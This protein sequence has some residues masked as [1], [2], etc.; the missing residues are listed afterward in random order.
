MEQPLT[1]NVA[2][3]KEQIN[4]KL[5]EFLRNESAQIICPTY[6]DVEL[7]KIRVKKEFSVEKEIL[8]TYKS[9]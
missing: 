7:E 4:C 9:I 5:F 6:L 8:Q 3:R 1:G 2:D